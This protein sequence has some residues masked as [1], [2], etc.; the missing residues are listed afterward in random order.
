HG[1]ARVGGAGF[2]VLVVG[3][4]REGVA[5]AGAE[6]PRV[7]VGTA[8]VDDVALLGGAGLVLSHS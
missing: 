3:G 6:Q 8:A 4:L 5:V 1:V 2:R 7:L